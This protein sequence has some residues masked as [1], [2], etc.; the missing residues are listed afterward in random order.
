MATI[1][2]DPKQVRQLP[3]C[4]TVMGNAGEAMAVGKVCQI[5]A[6]SDWEMANAGSA[7]GVTGQLGIVVAG[8]LYDPDGDIANNERIT[9]VIWGPVFLGENAA[10]DETKT[11]YV[12]ATDGVIQDVAPAQ[13]RAV[14]FA[15]N[16]TTLIFAPVTTVPAS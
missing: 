4:I 10:L 6:D 5:V 15:K 1:T 16:A 7:A 12:S 13:Y 9:L 8:N 14:G 2:V 3:G 11:Y